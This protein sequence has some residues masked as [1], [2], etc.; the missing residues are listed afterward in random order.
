MKF[1]KDFLPV[2]EVLGSFLKQQWR[3]TILAFS[4]GSTKEGE[5]QSTTQAEEEG[6]VSPLS[7]ASKAGVEH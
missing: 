4:H 6:Q 3:T 5:T 2:P 7:V 1:V